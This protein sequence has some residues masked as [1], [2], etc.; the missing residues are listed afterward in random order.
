MAVE[1]EYTIIDGFDHEKLGRIY[2][3]KK[4]VTVNGLD[5][6][7]DLFYIRTEVIGLEK[8]ES[9]EFSVN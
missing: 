9:R 1:I 3:A 6:R 4:V 2:I 5:I 8:D 7:N